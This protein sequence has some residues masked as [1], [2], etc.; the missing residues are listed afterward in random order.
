V[1]TRITNSP[2]L[3]SLCELLGTA[4]DFTFFDAIHVAAALSRLG[5]HASKT[6]KRAQL[7][8]NLDAVLRELVLRADGMRSAFDGRH[9]ANILHGVA[10]S[11][12]LAHAALRESAHWLVHIIVHEVQ[13]RR[14]T[15][16][17]GSDLVNVAWA[18]ATMRC[19]CAWTDALELV[20]AS[21]TA[22]PTLT[23]L[24]PPLLVNLAW[25]LADL[26]RAD[27]ALLNGVASAVTAREFVGFGPQDVTVVMQS[28]AALAYKNEPFVNGVFLFM[29]D[30][31][32]SRLGPGELASFAWALARLQVFYQTLLT[33]VSNAVHHFTRFDPE[34]MCSLA[35]AFATLHIRAGDVAEPPWTS[36]S[37]LHGLPDG[38]NGLVAWQRDLDLVE[39]VINHCYRVDTSAFTQKQLATLLWS[40]AKVRV[41]HAAFYRRLKRAL[42]ATIAHQHHS[43]FHALTTDEC[44]QLAWA[45]CE[46]PSSDA[47]DKALLNA[48]ADDVVAT[49]QSSRFTVASA[50]QLL[51][52]FACANML[53]RSNVQAVL[54]LHS[55][56]DALAHQDGTTVEA[57]LCRDVLAACA[58]SNT[59]AESFAVLD[60]LQRA[61]WVLRARTM[62]PRVVTEAHATV[63]RHLEERG[64]ACT[65][66]AVKHYVM[67]DIV[68]TS[69]DGLVMHVQVDGPERFFSDGATPTGATR[70]KREQVAALRADCVVC[71]REIDVGGAAL[72]QLGLEALAT[73]CTSEALS[74]VG[75]APAPRAV[76][77][78]EGTGPG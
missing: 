15:T 34:A 65:A 16:L 63:M 1:T 26:G 5:K 67:V 38:F 7:P 3:A 13:A 4:G 39:T 6:D 10:V 30:D 70:F 23:E 64:F 11:G 66:H 75:V 24:S 19:G 57:L 54:N 17:N 68:A 40:C 69:P 50:A 55:L 61:P 44:C 53:G 51:W 73:E 21:L 71:V 46:S 76:R 42:H 27:V 14:A 8:S 18:L 33:R 77:S 60:A 56:A 20:F 28:M 41:E 9:L 45:I 58:L 36:S 35:W 52:A 29:D 59:Q 31:T 47:N 62:A 72:S 37:S 12:F 22:L 2:T 74:S 49:R 48:L 25:T 43:K 78:V 32:L